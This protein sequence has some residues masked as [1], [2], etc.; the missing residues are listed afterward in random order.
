MGT[1]EQ[2]GPH[3]APLRITVDALSAGTLLH[4]HGELDI[5]AL[6]VLAH[7]I[8][9]IV[10]QPE[11][12]V[13][14]DL[15]ELEFCD[16]TGLSGIISALKRVRAADGELA[17]TGVHGRCARVLLRTGM[18]HVFPRYRN[19]GDAAL[20]LAEAPAFAPSPI[21]SKA[22]DRS[23]QGAGECRAGRPSGA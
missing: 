9:G 20:A 4:L 12:Y 3:H 13:V 17:L 8:D 10:A 5:A 11:P 6:A 21:K 1:K 18:D 19:V 2:A 7:E 22:G 16:S 23:L 14:L 15:S